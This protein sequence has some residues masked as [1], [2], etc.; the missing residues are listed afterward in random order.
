MDPYLEEPDLWPDVHLMLLTR[1]RADINP[2]L[3]EEY[4]ARIDR[5]VWL[6]ESDGE[7]VT[8]AGK[9]DVFVTGPGT[10]PMAR[11]AVAL[12]APA[13]AVLPAVRH[14]GNRY[15]RIIDAKSRRVVTVIELQSPSNK[16]PGPDHD[17]YLA[18]RDEYL[19]TRRM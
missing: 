18:K 11:T 1:I 10:E 3:P 14:E 8:R 2:R 16:T 9:P 4:V 13:T 15:L 6:E 12:M 7:G 19:G 17:H 5:Y